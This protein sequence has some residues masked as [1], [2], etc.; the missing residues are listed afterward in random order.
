MKTII[1]CLPLANDQDGAHWIG[2]EHRPRYRS[3]HK[4]HN[5]QC[6]MRNQFDQP[7]HSIPSYASE[8]S[9]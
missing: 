9:V 6:N 4:Y 5:V 1:G 7:S 8:G 2:L 3:Y